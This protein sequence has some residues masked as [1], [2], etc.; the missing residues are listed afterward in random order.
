MAPIDSPS[1]SAPVTDTTVDVRPPRMHKVL[2]HNDDYTTQEF[3]TAILCSVFGKSP[4][5][6]IRIMLSVHHEGIGVAGVYPAQIAE[7]KT[8]EVHKR[9]RAAEYPLRC[10]TEPE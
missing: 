7:A 8:A 6:A 2:L 3:V 10:S 9:A 4:A 5:D 1:W